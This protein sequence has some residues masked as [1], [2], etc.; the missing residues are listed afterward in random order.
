MTWRD[1]GSKLDGN[2]DVDCDVKQGPTPYSELSDNHWPL[3]TIVLDK[4]ALTVYIAPA[5]RRGVSACRGIVCTEY[6]V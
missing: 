4:Y 1:F 2:R 3:G 6:G 5:L